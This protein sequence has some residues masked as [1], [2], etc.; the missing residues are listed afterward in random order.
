MFTLLSPSQVETVP[1]VGERCD[2][3][4]SA[5]KLGFEIAAGG[6][7]AMCG[8]HANRHAAEIARTAVRIRVEDGFAWTGAPVTA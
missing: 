8:H 2:A 3:C 4:G 6:T 5:A 7:L 1:S